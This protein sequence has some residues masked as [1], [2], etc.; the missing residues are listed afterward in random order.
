MTGT[1]AA[2]SEASP[3]A[4]GLGRSLLLIGRIA[5]GVTFVAAAY[6]K[7]HF[8]GEWHMGDYQFFFA[9]T[10]DSYKMLPIAAVE[11]LARILPWLELLLGGVLMAG[12]GL[13]WA[14][15]AAS[16]LLCVFIAAML[17]AYLLHLEINCGC[18]GPNEKLGGLSLLRDSSL[19]A[20]SLAVAAGAFL[21]R[22][23]EAKV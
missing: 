17:R 20:L 4:G 21:I 23:R 14:A 16:A 10:I 22:K 19:L 5:L 7:L 1:P 11:W 13:R 6:T 8:N 18:F 3:R 12:A 2:T 9:M 15:S